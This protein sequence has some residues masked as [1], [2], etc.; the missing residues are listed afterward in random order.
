MAQKRVLTWTLSSNPNSFL[1]YTTI[2]KNTCNIL[3]SRVTGKLIGIKLLKRMKNV[4]K[5][6]PKFCGFRSER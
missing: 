1:L 3:T 5:V 6:K 4:K 2:S